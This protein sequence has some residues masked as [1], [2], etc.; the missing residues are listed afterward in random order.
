MQM[1]Q[2]VTLRSDNQYQIA[3]KFIINSAENLKW[4]NSFVVLNILC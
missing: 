1:L 2:I 3:H 4:F